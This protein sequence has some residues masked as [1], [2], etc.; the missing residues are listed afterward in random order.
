[1]DTALKPLVI[2]LHIPYCIRPEKYQNH[3]GAVG[4]NEEKNAYLR[5]LRREVLS[6]EGEL[7]GYEIQAV[8]LSGSSATV[9]H[10]D[11]LGDLLSTVRERLPVARGA[12]VGF[13]ALPN[14]IG[15]PSL[16]GIGGGRPNRVEVMMRSESDEE[17]RALGCAFGYENVQNAMLFLGKFHMNNIGLTVNYGIPGQDVVSWHNTLHACTIM[18]PAHIMVEPL[19]QTDAPGMP[20]AQKRFEMYAHACQYLKESG[21]AQY[22]ARH[23]CLPH[24]E[25]LCE[26]LIMDGADV[27]GMGVNAVSMFDGY[28]TR[29][30]NNLT[31]YV[32]NAG[33]MEKTTAKAY[34][35]TEQ[36]QML[37]YAAGRM[38]AVSGLRVA[39]F[40]GR[41]GMGVAEEIKEKL[42]ALA[43]KGFI[44]KDNAGFVPTVQGL[45]HAEEMK[46]VILSEKAGG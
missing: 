33:N 5:A 36:E 20:D 6:W 28:V 19:A 7:D 40:E 27:I 18:N 12:E 14:T 13:D 39:A 22:G 38:T 15:T 29:N 21:Y 25:Y 42:S 35:L 34:V 44:E 17:L 8:R 4:T 16:T 41:F 24:H 9:M 30:T 43:D 11:M 45:F 2:D 3:F 23:F 37:A 32:K 26:A 46:A 31:L 10:P 1:M